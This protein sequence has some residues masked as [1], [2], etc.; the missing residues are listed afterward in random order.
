[1]QAVRTEQYKGI[2][3]FAHENV[4]YELYDLEKDPGETL[5]IAAEYPAIMDKIKAFMTEAYVYTE[6]Y[7]RKV[8]HSI[9]FE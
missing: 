3:N 7:P 1:M 8:V 5:N 9:H 4:T 6:A 2:A